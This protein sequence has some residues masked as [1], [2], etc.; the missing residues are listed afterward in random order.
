MTKISDKSSNINVALAL[1]FFTHLVAFGVVGAV[2]SMTQ[3]S[4]IKEYV[5]VE[6]VQMPALP[7]EVVRT[8]VAASPPTVKVPEPVI[9]KERSAA[10]PAQTVAPL[11]PLSQS[12]AEAP[13]AGS[14]VVP[15]SSA[16]PGEGTVGRATGSVSSPVRSTTGTSQPQKRNKGSYQAFHRLTRLPL[17]KMRA[18]PV[19]PN[20]ERMTGSEARVLAEIC[21]DERGA[22]DDVIIKKSGGK[23]FDKAV[24]DAARQSS[25]SPGYMGEKTV[26]CVIQIPYTFKLK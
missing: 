15:R 14:M 5:Q 11:L 23:L 6:L 16:A 1:S 4:V 22:V 19:Y 18:E 20:T 9:Q 26:P 24:I 13:S 7:H 2:Q 17:F 3:Q 10:P 12:H 21:L 25:F 8:R